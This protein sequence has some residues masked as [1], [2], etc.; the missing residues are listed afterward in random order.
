MPGTELVAPINRA[1]LPAYVKL[2]QDLPALGRE[3]LSVMAM[4]ALIAVPA[5]AGF[6]ATAPFLVLLILGPAWVDAAILLQILAFFGITQ[7]LQSNA[8]SAFLAVGQHHVFAKINGLHVAILLPLMTLGTVFYGL[9]GAA[10]AYVA[11]AMAILPVNFHSH[12]AIL[13]FERLAVRIF[14]VAADLQRGRHVP[15]RAYSSGRM[16]RRA[17][18][19]P[20]RPRAR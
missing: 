15:R 16:P 9:E 10:W 11:A 2:A 17:S 3:Y 19:R 8:Y 18:F 4:I 1:V 14:P 6:A 20:P 13:A 5:V 12:Y 7:V